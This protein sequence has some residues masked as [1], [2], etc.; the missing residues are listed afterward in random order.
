[1][2]VTFCACMESSYLRICLA[3]FSVLLHVQQFTKSCVLTCALK[4]GDFA[5]ARAVHIPLSSKSMLWGV[6]VFKI[7]SLATWAEVRC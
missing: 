5:K 2:V 1:M 4:P 3:A 7:M 6:V